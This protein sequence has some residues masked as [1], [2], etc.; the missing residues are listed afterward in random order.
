LP[1]V[2]STIVENWGEKLLAGAFIYVILVLALAMPLSPENPS[3]SKLVVPGTFEALRDTFN[4]W[5]QISGKVLSGSETETIIGIINLITS[6][7]KA[8]FEIL[9]SIAV[10][11]LLLGFAISSYLPGPLVIIK[12]LIWAGMFAANLILGLYLA[13]KTINVLRSIIS[14]LI[15]TAL[16]V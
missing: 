13:D 11:Y 1:M 9:F 7:M 3:L 15:P 5:N 8:L 14:S 12:S 10:A 2:L 16:G 6:G 4:T